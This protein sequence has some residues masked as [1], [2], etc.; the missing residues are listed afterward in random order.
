MRRW[1]SLV[2]LVRAAIGGRLWS[3][4]KGL[5]VQLQRNYAR[6]FSLRKSVG[7]QA[8]QRCCVSQMSGEATL[9]ERREERHKATIKGLLCG[10]L[11]CGEKRRMEREIS[12]SGSTAEFLVNS[13]DLFYV[14]LGLFV[15]RNTPVL[16]D[17][18]R[19]GIVGCQGE[20]Y[21]PLGRVSIR[22]AVAVDVEL[23]PQ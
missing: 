2:S 12:E 6:R 9:L 8:Y 21:L 13:H 22:P 1:H 5:Q 15:G 23:H 10:V 7:I 4:V 16:L 3:T 14:V 18:S 17:G 11:C 20:L 19:T